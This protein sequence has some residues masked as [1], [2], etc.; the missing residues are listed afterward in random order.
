[1]ANTYRDAEMAERIAQDLISQHHTHLINARIIWLASSGAQ[2]KARVC[3]ALLQHAFGK[4]ASGVF[5]AFVVTISDSD[6][7]ARNAD[8]RRA[9]VDELLC[10]MGQETNQTSGVDKW[11]INRPDVS[12]FLSVIK[13]HGLQTT[14][15]RQAGRIIKELP[16]Q[17]ALMLDADDEDSDQVNDEDEDEPQVTY[18]FERAD[19][20]WQD[21]EPPELND[22]AVREIRGSVEAA[23]K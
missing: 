8:A 21:A 12:M 20:T 14:E 10:S 6:W 5:P 18:G 1:M 16:E 9:F 3:P 2:S 11:I 23:V 13:R 7:S 17:L 19:G 15:Q 4:D 22:Q